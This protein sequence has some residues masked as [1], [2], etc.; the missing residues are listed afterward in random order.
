MRADENELITRFYYGKQEN[1][2]GISSS[3]VQRLQ[4]TQL[5]HKQEQAQYPGKT[6]V[7]KV[8]SA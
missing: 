3:S 7:Q 4:K 2:G 5:H 1:N 8:L 6:G